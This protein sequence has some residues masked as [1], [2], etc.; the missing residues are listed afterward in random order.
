MI[1]L[2]TSILS[3]S[4]RRKYRKDIDKPSEVKLLEK[5]IL[6]NEPLVISGIVL[7]EFLSGLKEEAQFQRLQKLGEFFPI[8]MATKQ[9]HIEAAK[10]ANICRR[11]GVATSATDCLIAAITIEKNGQL[12]TIDR[13]FGYMADYCPIRLVSLI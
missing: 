1:F 4:Y 9:H 8:I 12:F 5:M 11:N 2:D 10:I 7:Q 3:I 6:D 13:D